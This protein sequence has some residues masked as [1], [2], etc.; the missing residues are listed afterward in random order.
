MVTLVR[1]LPVGVALV[2]LRVN[3]RVYRAVSDRLT[4]RERAA[5]RIIAGTCLHAGTSNVM[6]SEREVR[7]IVAA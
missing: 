1:H 4:A 3:G 5:A 7:A 6:L 2:H